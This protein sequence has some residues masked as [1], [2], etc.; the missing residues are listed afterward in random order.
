MAM[1]AMPWD[2]RLRVSPAIASDEARAGDGFLAEELHAA[3]IAPE[4]QAKPQASEDV[5]DP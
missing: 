5:G 2:A 4:D 3:V 1:I